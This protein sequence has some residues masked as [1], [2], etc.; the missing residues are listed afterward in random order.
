MFFSLVF[1]GFF[2]RLLILEMEISDKSQ[3]LILLIRVR[4]IKQ[5]WCQIWSIEQGTENWDFKQWQHCVGTTTLF[6]VVTDVF[7]I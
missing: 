7:I 6:D 4:F 1:I 2:Y 3:S 5:S